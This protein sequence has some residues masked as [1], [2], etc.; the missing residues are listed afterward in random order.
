MF[1]T[2]N[3]YFHPLEFDT[4]EVLPKQ[5]TFP[6]YYTP[7]P[8]CIA[9]ANDLKAYLNTQNDFQHNFGLDDAKQGLKI[10][11]MFGVMIVQT[12]DQQLGYITSFS[13]KLADSN[14]LKGFVP[15]IYDTL[16]KDGFYK[17]NEARVNRLTTEI[18]SLEQSLVR[19]Q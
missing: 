12:H 18:E 2:E 15:P 4:S 5:F 17:Q 14:H 16:H 6:F 13:G 3:G 8:L 9:A 7:H 11:K 10:G 19:L 1:N